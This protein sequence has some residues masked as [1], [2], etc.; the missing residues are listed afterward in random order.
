MNSDRVTVCAVKI[1]LCDFDTLSEPAGSLADNSNL[2]V[3]QICADSIV[4]IRTKTSAELFCNSLV[5]KYKFSL[6]VVRNTIIIGYFYRALSA[7][8]DVFKIKINIER[9]IV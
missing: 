8:T 2:T 5:L 9:A 6:N 4:A 7:Q 1:N 3:N